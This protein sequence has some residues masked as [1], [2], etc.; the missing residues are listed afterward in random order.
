[1]LSRRRRFLT[2]AG[3]LLAAASPLGAIRQTLADEAK[4]VRPGMRRVSGNVWIN[5]R[6]A[7]EGSLVSAGDTVTTAAD[8][9]AV[10]VIGKDAFL[11]RADSQVHF[12]M[13]AGQ[14]FRMLSG[15]LLSVFGPGEKMLQVPTATIGIRGTACYLEAA[16]ERT[17]F[18]LCYGT[19]DIT[20][21]DHPTQTK[22]I[23]T[24]HHDQPMMLY[25]HVGKAIGME[26]AAVINHWDAELV[27]LEALQGRQPPFGSQERY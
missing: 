6:K 8:A 23:T 13:L 24:Q 19:A 21:T 18:C 4:P 7:Q 15:R 3:S 16:R 22:R 17:Y 5:D 27:M 25:A 9:E 11:Q 26:E 20:L 12:G 14:F 10:Y 2:G 1:M